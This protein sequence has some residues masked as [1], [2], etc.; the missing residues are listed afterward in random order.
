MEPPPDA[1]PGDARSTGETSGIER[2]LRHRLLAVRTVAISFRAAMESA[3]RHLNVAAA[4]RAEIKERW[5]AWAHETLEGYER[6]FE[7]LVATES[8]SGD[9]A[10]AAAD[11]Y[12][13]ELAKAYEIVRTTIGD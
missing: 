9:G 5:R 7:D 10:R 4:E 11:R 6:E 8:V 2:E 12:R 13:D 1:N 3:E